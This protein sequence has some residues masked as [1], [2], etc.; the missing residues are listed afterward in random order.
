VLGTGGSVIS[1]AWSRKVI[2]YGVGYWW[3]RSNTHVGKPSV[4]RFEK[5][6]QLG[7]G[8]LRHPVK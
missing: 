1:Y 2:R 6:C 7:G 5:P 8:H 4:F 3:F